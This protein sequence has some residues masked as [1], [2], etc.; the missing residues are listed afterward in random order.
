[1]AKSHTP[2]IRMPLL[3]T[4]AALLAALLALSALFPVTGDD[5]Y[6]ET[7][8]QNLHTLSELAEL[9]IEKYQTTN[10]RLLGNLLAYCA[11]S[12]AALRAVL[13]GG[14]L[15]IL[16]LAAAKNINRLTPIPVL[17]TFTALLVLPQA[18]F[19]QV[20]PWAAGFFNYVPPVATTLL[21]FVLAR[22][23]FEK[24]P[25]RDAPSAALG[26]FLLGFSGQL[27]IEH[28]TLYALLASLVLLAWYILEQ[29]R[30]SLVLF[31]HT[32]G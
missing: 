28:N 9:L 13:R 6:R 20:Y 22:P 32:A 2:G 8:G 3:L 11:G 10:P 4:L 29:R 17:L 16:I 27:F 30:F 14:I 15:F 5:W 25:M 24:E 7:V 1:M 31:F 23:V 19:A 26:A 18:M 21:F 12:H